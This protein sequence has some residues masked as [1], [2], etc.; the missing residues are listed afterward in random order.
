VTRRRSPAATPRWQRLAADFTHH[1]LYLC[2]VVQ[3]VTGFL[4]SLSSPFPAKYFGRTL[5]FGSWDVPAAKEILGVVHLANATLL[6]VLIVVHI[7][8][9]LHHVARRDGVLRRMWFASE[10]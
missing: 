10:R 6:S 4:G 2:V 7:A 1:A 9:V 5:P 8:A 3:P